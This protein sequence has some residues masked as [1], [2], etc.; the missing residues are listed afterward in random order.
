M[1]ISEAE[2]RRPRATHSFESCDDSVVHCL[3][4]LSLGRHERPDDQREDHP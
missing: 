1:V 4:A 2:L 3:R